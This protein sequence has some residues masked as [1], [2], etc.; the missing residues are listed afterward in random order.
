MVATVSLPAYTPCDGCG[1]SLAVSWIGNPTLPVYYV[2]AGFCR[3]C[4]RLRVGVFGPD[5]RVRRVLLAD[6][7]R[8]VEG[9]GFL[10]RA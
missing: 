4:Y 2:G 7:R 1:A 10:E 8:S 9:S 5:A 6:F 3:H